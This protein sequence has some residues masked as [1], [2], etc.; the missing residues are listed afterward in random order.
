MDILAVY[1]LKLRYGGDRLEF[2]RISVLSNPA[3]SPALPEYSS[4]ISSNNQNF[5]V[6][7]L[8]K[9]NDVY[10]TL[11]FF[12]TADG[13][14]HTKEMKADFYDDKTTVLLIEIVIGCKPTIQV[15]YEWI[16]S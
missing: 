4:N 2:S 3:S 16:N 7:G 5:E 6:Y 8:K 13:V 1:N 11:T 12:C 15:I 10:V 14:F 9:T